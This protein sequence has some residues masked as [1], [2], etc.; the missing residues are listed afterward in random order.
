MK[1]NGGVSLRGAYLTHDTSATIAPQ[2]W[3][4]E[5]DDFLL[6][7]KRHA[8]IMQLHRFETRHGFWCDAHKQH[9]RNRH[10]LIITVTGVQEG[11]V[12]FVFPSP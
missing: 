6:A 10:V 8:G 12:C 7:V 5:T 1:L 9:G 2:L 3:L 4:E 11:F